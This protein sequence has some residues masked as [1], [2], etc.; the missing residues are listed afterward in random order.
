MADEVTRQLITA[1]A[2]GFGTH[3]GQ[4]KTRPAY[5]L[6][7][8]VVRRNSHWIPEYGLL[9]SEEIVV[10]VDR[11]RTWRPIKAVEWELIPFR[12]DLSELTKLQQRRSLCGCS[13]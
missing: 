9:P 10:W 4:W 8:L 5:Q 12:F 6:S 2:H 3:D 11:R 1:S 7:R 13:Q